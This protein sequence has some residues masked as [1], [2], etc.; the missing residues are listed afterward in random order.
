MS[1]F[2]VKLLNA[3]ESYILYMFGGER[4]PRKTGTK[5]LIIYCLL[6][7]AVVIGALRVNKMQL[8]VSDWLRMCRGWPGHLQISLYKLTTGFVTSWL[9]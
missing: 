3:R 1:G 5:A 4:H 7:T 9:F 2:L 6:F 8:Y